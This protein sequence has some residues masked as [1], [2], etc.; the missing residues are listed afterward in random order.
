M[1]PDTTYQLH[2]DSDDQPTAGSSSSDSN[3]SRRPEAPSVY[4][5]PQS[6]PPPK[7]SAVPWYLRPLSKPSNAPL[8]STE[9]RQYDARQSLPPLRQP[10][11]TQDQTTQQPQSDPVSPRAETRDEAGDQ[12]AQ[13][14]QAPP[15]S[16]FRSSPQESSA[17]PSMQTTAEQYQ[18]PPRPPLR[19]PYQRPGSPG[20][21]KPFSQFGSAASSESV[22]SDPPKKK[23][24]KL[25]FILIAL[26]IL[27]IAGIGV[28]LFALWKNSNTQPTANP[29]AS[30]SEDKKRLYKA[31]EHHLTTD[32][33]RQV[34]DQTT[35]GADTSTVKLTVVSNFSD[36]AKPTSAIK[37]EVTSGK[38][39]AA[40]NGAG[41]IVVV[42]SD[43]YYGNLTKP[44]MFY[45]GQENA[46]PKENQWYIVG[47]NDATND[48]MFD[49][50]AARSSLNSSQGEIPVGLFDD[51]T[52]KELLQ[53]IK[54][55]DVYHVKSS[56]QVTE[57]GKKATH[58]SVEF[59]ADL[60]NE[61][62]QKVATAI[63]DVPDSAIK[64]TNNDTKNMEIWVTNDDAKIVRVKIDRE[65]KAGNNA[66]AV[67]E[68]TNLHITYPKD[69]PEITPPK[70]AV[71]I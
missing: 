37:Y 2:P 23:M 21:P 16:P 42:D 11:P 50:L 10:A 68:T 33:I 43:K 70:D 51:A 62:N 46:K 67:K 54:N 69:T 58:Y 14:I 49:P 18:A 63:G 59:N 40:I 22:K 52:R 65:T 45:Q 38:D 1:K 4:D 15:L 5:Q 53:F 57:N 36:P 25:P 60:I 34:Y 20:T 39:K 17:D 66:A 7:P 27:L 47:V 26:G 31:I 24:K 3:N 9:T 64:F 35:T 48:M 32:K 41:E 30:V 12:A 29:A 55:R 6:T 44:V 19:S 56:N 28:G 8:T 71:A 61:L 13:T